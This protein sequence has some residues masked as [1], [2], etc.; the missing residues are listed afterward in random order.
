MYKR[1][2][3][4]A[5][6]IQLHQEI[7]NQCCVAKIRSSRDYRH[8]KPIIFIPNAAAAYIIFCRTHV[9]Y[10]LEATP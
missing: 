8:Q 4:I 1:I 3:P 5:P 6:D 10:K 2:V 9:A 7:V